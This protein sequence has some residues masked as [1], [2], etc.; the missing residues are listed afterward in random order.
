MIVGCAINHLKTR[1]SRRARGGV[2]RD[3]EEVGKLQSIV[4]K[5]STMPGLLDIHQS[6]ANIRPGGDLS[7]FA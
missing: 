4:H 6:F 5:L 7:D 2:E 3:A 1:F